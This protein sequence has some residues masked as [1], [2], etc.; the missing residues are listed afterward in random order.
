MKYLS[1]L[2]LNILLTLFF[3][4]LKHFQ[5]ETDHEPKEEKSRKKHKVKHVGIS[6]SLMLYFGYCGYLH[7]N[8][9]KQLGTPTSALPPCHCLSFGIE[10]NVSYKS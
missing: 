7:T 6:N 10:K 8:L 9:N 1:Q 5:S 4:H 3:F 2:R